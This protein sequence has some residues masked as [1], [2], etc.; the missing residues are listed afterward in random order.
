MGRIRHA[1][2]TAGAVIG[3]RTLVHRR[4]TRTNAAHHEFFRNLLVHALQ[5]INAAREAGD[6]EDS[7]EIDRRFDRP[8]TRLAVYGSLAPGKSNHEII[9]DI[10]GTWNPGFVRGDLLRKGWGTHVGFPGMTWDPKSRNRINVQVF[11]SEDLPEHW[12]RLDDFEGKDYLR[13]LVPVESLA[14]A[15]IVA[16]IYRVR[17]TANGNG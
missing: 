7:A 10:A 6:I 2:R 16:N 12:D 15:P 8:S 13:I 11:T 17:R 14:D 9:K 4:V 1:D 3:D 5:A